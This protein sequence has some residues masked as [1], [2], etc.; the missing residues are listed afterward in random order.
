MKGTC[1]AV[2]GCLGSACFV[3]VYV[4]RIVPHQGGIQ[5]LSSTNTIMRSAAEILKLQQKPKEMY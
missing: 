2:L 5:A 3:G 4:Y 1:N